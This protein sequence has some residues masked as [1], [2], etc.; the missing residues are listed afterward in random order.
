VNPTTKLLSKLLSFAEVLLYATH[1]AAIPLFIDKLN[2]TTRNKTAKPVYQVWLLKTKLKVIR[3][4]VL[5]LDT[6][7]TPFNTVSIADVSQQ[8]LTKTNIAPKK[9]S[10]HFVLNGLQSCVFILK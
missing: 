10:F 8:R 3:G 7:C 2:K 9:Q 5:R 6:V 4:G 1:K